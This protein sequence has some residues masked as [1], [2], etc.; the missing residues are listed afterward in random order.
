[1]KK[2]QFLCKI[3]RFFEIIFIFKLEPIVSP[4]MC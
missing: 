2:A 3:Y 4:T 1:L